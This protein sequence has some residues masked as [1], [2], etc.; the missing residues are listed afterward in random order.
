[1]DLFKDI[2]SVSRITVALFVPKG[3]GT[4]IHK[5]RPAHGFAFNVGTASTYR[6]DSGECLVCNSGDLIY[7]PRGSSYQVEKGSFCEI[8]GGGVYAVNFLTDADIID[9]EVNR[10]SLIHVKGTDII[11]SMFRKAAKAWSKKNIGYYEECMAELYRIIRLLKIELNEYTPREK[12]LATLM[13]ALKYISEN[14]RSQ[15]ISAER[16]ATLSGVSEPYLRRLF[17][18]MF[19]VSPAVYIRNM[20]IA[21]AKELLAARGYS[22]TEVASLSGFNDA[23][24]F[25]REFKKSVGISPSDYEGEF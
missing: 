8:E 23:A 9:A 12:N 11:H 14:Y 13:P 22:I 24:Y 5:N 3:N 25:S 18:R 16:L 1:M 17:Q 6:F 4:P 7:L 2:F 19:S 10:P 15:T 20:R 21:Y